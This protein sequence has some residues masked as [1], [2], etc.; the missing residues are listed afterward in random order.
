MRKSTASL[1]AFAYSTRC[2]RL[3]TS[4]FSYGPAPAGFAC[5]VMSFAVCKHVVL[6]AINNDVHIFIDGSDQGAADGELGGDVGAAAASGRRRGARGGE[7]GIG[8]AAAAPA[9]RA[10]S[11]SGNL[12]SQPRPCSSPP[13]RRTP[14]RRSACGCR[15]R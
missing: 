10:G 3:S 11:R 15:A 8:V 12:P 13:R 1:C 6:L 14:S 5:A 9:E 2:K 4:S 7:C